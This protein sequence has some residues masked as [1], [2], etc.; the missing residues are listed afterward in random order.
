LNPN[1]EGQDHKPTAELIKRAQAI[2]N[3]DERRRVIGEIEELR[4]RYAGTEA[5]F[6]S[7]NGQPSGLLAALGEEH[8]QQAWYAVRTPSFK[9]W[10]GDWEQ[11]ARVEAVEKLASKEITT[12]ETRSKKEFEEMARSFKQIKN[13][14][15]G[16]ITDIPRN[17]I[18]KIYGHKGYDISRIIEHIPTLYETSISGWSEPE[19]QRE[20]HKPRTNIKAFHHYINKFTD[21]TGE[22]FIR[23][24]INEEKTKPGKDAKNKIHSTAVSD[25][26]IYK[27]GDGPQ[28]I[29]GIYPGEANSSP[30]HD[31]RLAVFFNSVKP[32]SVS[33]II[34]EN[35]EPLPVYRGD[36]PEQEIF[37]NP[38]GVSLAG[39]KTV[40]ADYSS[41]GLFNL[42]VDIKNPLVLNENSFNNIRE[43]INN[44]LEDIYEQ[45]WSELE[46]NAQYQALRENYLAFR[47]GEGSAVRD[48]YNNFLPDVSEDTPLDGFKEIL[49]KSV[50]DANTFEWQQIDYHDIDI[51]N[52]FIKALGYDGVA[53]PYDPLGQAKDKEFIAFEPNQIKSATENTGTYNRSDPS[54][55]DSGSKQ[56]ILKELSM[57]IPIS[58]QAE[59]DNA[60]KN[61][62]H[63]GNELVIQNTKD[64]IAVHTDV[65]VGKNGR[66]QTGD[67]CTSTI[68]ARDNG[69]VIAEGKTTVIGHDNANII[70]K[71]NCSITLKDAA[72]GSCYDHCKITLKDESKISADG[73]CTV[74]AYDRS[75]IT[76]TG[77]TKVYSFQ[78]ST[79][80]GSGVSAIDA[81]DNCIVYASANCSVKATDNCLVVA[82]KYALIAA[83]DNCLILSVDNP[84]DNITLVGKKCEHIK[85]ED[86]NEKNVMSVLKQMANSK[87][88]IERPYVAVELL[89]ENIPPQRKEAVNKRLNTLGLKDPV[90][91]KNYLAGMVEI[92]S[93]VK[94]T[95]AQNFEQ[96]LE[97]A[98]KTG[99]VQ[100]VC[101]CVAVVGNEKNMGAKLLSEM[102]VNKD[103]AKK[104]A[105]PETYKTLEQGIFAQKPEQ[106]V[107]NSFKR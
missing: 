21:G 23:F 104:Y 102:N 85:L 91:T 31:S 34:D 72:S 35:G 33:K 3:P 1:Q 44:M 58:T 29:R 78:S 64:T 63:I 74:H 50:H 5:E 73:N 39:D 45:D 65:T 42:F 68:T 84:K 69:V 36:K 40:A 87:A 48:F 49:L 62:Q 10:F 59:Y 75:D 67:K 17:T 11:A 105:N 32:Y 80:K 2:S 86:I 70:A 26:T 52:P 46:H 56:T 30:F 61:R 94:K 13:N 51:L 7:P 76:A 98:R 54:I 88:V 90:S 4:Q 60:V 55:T 12:S 99:Y 82:S 89:K 97:T 14:I 24:T 57:Q 18:G 28:R 95:S 43:Q 22:Y 15:D 8:G 20:G 77:S 38:Q 47:N 101:E 6:K 79:A 81:K 96:Q 107:E 16:R 25:I 100:G 92:E 53:R 103:M 71:G 37:A 83:A 41:G 106:K 27:K 19:I 66:C 9:N 93:A